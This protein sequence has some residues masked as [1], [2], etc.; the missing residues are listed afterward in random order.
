[1]EVNNQ[2]NQINQVMHLMQSTMQVLSD[3]EKQFEDLLNADLN[4]TE[5]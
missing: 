1:M 5:I 4:Q 2:A 3:Y